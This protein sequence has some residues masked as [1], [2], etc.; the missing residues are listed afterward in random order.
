MDSVSCRFS[1]GTGTAVC[2]AEALGVLCDESGF[3]SAS[4][5]EVSALFATVTSGSLCAAP[6]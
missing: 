6:C 2:F 4:D 5:I 1:S 3:E